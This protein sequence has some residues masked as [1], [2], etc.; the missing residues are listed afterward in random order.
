MTRSDPGSP[1]P[2]SPDSGANEDDAVWRDL[3][4]RLEGT[5]SGPAPGPGA[6]TS[7]ARTFRDFDPLG[8]SVP[9]QLTPP[10]GTRPAAG[11]GAEGSADRD[12]PPGPRDYEADEDEGAFVPEEPPSLASSDPMTVLAW[13]GAV[14]G[15]IALLLSAIFWRSAPLLAV[16]GMV[17]A[18]AASVVFLIMKLPHEK[19]EHDDGARV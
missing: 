16:V 11:G 15:P 18:F 1:D 13:L 19:D 10:A 7:A 12:A 5:D 4:A 8:L 17:A 3:V 6:G 14:G 9:P 2:D